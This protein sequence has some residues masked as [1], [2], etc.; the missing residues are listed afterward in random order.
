MFK[1]VGHAVAISLLVKSTRLLFVNFRLPNFEQTHRNAGLPFSEANEVNAYPHV[2]IWKST[3]TTLCFVE[4]DGSV[5]RLTRSALRLT[6][7]TNATEASMVHPWRQMRN[8][9]MASLLQQLRKVHQLQGADLIAQFQGVILLGSF[10]YG[11]VGSY[12]SVA[13]MVRTQHDP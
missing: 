7:G 2:D 4:V 11:C 3:D 6:I 12:N 13:E 9:M 1:T 8:K 10:N 5:D